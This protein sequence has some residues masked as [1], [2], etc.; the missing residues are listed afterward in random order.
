MLSLDICLVT[1]K[2]TQRLYRTSVVAL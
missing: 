2:E 1:S